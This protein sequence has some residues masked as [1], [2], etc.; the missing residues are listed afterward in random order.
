[1]L[2]LD[3]RQTVTRLMEDNPRYL[4]VLDRFH[5]D[6][7]FAGGLTLSEVCLMQGLDLQELL[8]QLR[9][10]DREAAFLDDTVL[11]SMDVPELVEY[12]L[13]AHHHFLERE[14]PRLEDLFAQAIHTE[15]EDRPE[16]LEWLALYRRFRWSMERH[17]KKQGKG[18]FPYCLALRKGPEEQVREV[19]RLL[20]E[21][22]GEDGEGREGLRRLK[23]STDG[24][25][26]PDGADR[27]T[28]YLL[29]DLG[30]LES[31]VK[32]HWRVEQDILFPKAL[33]FI[34]PGPGPMSRT[35][36]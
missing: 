1:M 32:R 11:E 21:L 12:I 31:E 20:D 16:L 10:S 2:F 9:E 15:G 27:A 25:L 30:R 14:L 18:L 28:R 4:R 26:I 19:Q 17:M 35:P 6:Y 34:P 8:G 13:F 29:H 23:R 24:Y 3:P 7:G 36:H 22:E 33:S 5:I